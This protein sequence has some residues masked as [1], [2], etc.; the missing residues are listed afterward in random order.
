MM[1]TFVSQCEKNAL[2]KTRRVLDA[3]ANRIGDNTWQT[4]ITEDGLQTVKKM[5]RKTA[6]RSTAVSCHWI[7]SRSRTQL[8]WVVGNRLKFNAEG[9]VPVNRTQLNLEHKEWEQGWYLNEAVV[10]AT[11]IAALWHDFG[12]AN[13]LFQSK[14]QGLTE[15]KG[16]P[17]RHEWVS[18]R[19]FLAFVKRKPD[20]EWLS[21]LA[22]LAEQTLAEQVQRDILANLIRDDLE[23]QRPF[24]SL[25]PFAKLVAWLVVTHHRTLYVQSDDVVKTE[26]IDNW[27]NSVNC[28]WNSTNEKLGKED[29][30]L[31][32]KNWSFGNG[33][34]LLSQTWRDKAN[35]LAKRALNYPELLNRIDWFEQRFVAHMARLSLM[36]ADHYYSSLPLEQ[37][38]ATW[39]D[40][41]YLAYANTDRATNQLKQKLDQHNIGVAVNAQRFAQNLPALRHTL[42]ALAQHKLFTRRSEN[43]KYQWQDRAF[44]AAKEV[45]TLSERQG[46]FGVNMASTGCGKTMANA[47]IMY[48]LSDERQG[49]RFSVALGLR[50]LT[51]QTGDAY[52]DLLK[53]GDDELAVLIGSQAVKALH[54]LNQQQEFESKSG[55][56]SAEDLL[57]QLYVSYEGQIYDGRLKH[58]LA[59]SPKLEQLVSAPILVSTIDHLMPASESLRGGKQIAPMLR[60]LSSDL[61]LDEP[62]D[63]G[64]ED[65]P[66]LCRLVNWAGMLGS[67][68]LLSSATLPPSLISTLFDAYLEGRKQFNQANFAG[69]ADK[70]VVCAWFD[71]FK[72][73]TAELVDKTSFLAEHKAF[74]DKRIVKLGQIEQVI[75]KGALVPITSDSPKTEAVYQTVA[76]TIYQQIHALHQQ[77]HVSHP[78][79][80]KVSLGVVRMANIKPMMA[81]AK[82]LTAMAPDADTSIHFCVYHSQYPLALRSHKE[83]RLDAILTRHDANA[84]WQHA[85][86]AQALEATQTKNNIFVVLGT[87]VVEVGRD[88]DYDWA[89]AEPSSLRSLIQLAGRIQRHRQLPPAT[90]NLMVLS[91]NVRALKGEVPAYAKPGFESRELPLASHDLQ[92]LLDGELEAIS[93]IPRIVEP[94]KFLSKS[95]FQCGEGD[96]ACVVNSFVIQEHRALRIAL[97]DI[98][99]GMYRNHKEASLWWKEE[100]AWSGEFVHQTEFRQ[101]SPQEALVLRYGDDDELGWYQLDTTRKPYCYTAKN[102]SFKADACLLARG[103]Y[104]WFDASAEVIYQQLAERL[105]IDA[106]KASE[107]FGEIRLRM[108]HKDQVAIEWQWHPQ[109]GVY[110]Q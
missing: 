11:S 108:P 29:P 84:L 105:A 70:P 66:A 60:L 18:L 61:V 23:P 67:R 73:V 22:G 56:E 74:V 97:N 27:L 35:K 104:W 30:A 7:R 63:F 9:V 90:P 34:P 8:L 75:R 78:S 13:D 45:A 26:N 96:K 85:E 54:Q 51:L 40:V 20:H 41:N 28:G 91:Q 31:C 16:E 64:L 42:P 80:R 71:E 59:A 32:E 65:L 83:N 57:D 110:E 107:Q 50:T 102:N 62:D 43:A 48:A 81:V 109:L 77:H 98:G 21:Q 72:S 94:P 10:L 2:K 24:I 12:K 33:L 6:S 93:A 100:I 79:G 44:K 14:L 106:G 3:F 39:C 103:C 86:I 89:I 69:Q 92:Q 88:H 49:C 5:L 58:W 36:L 47:R 38:K 101:S 15:S 17:Y 37:S 99:Q 68:V 52:R 1:V 53:L 82:L 46:F 87:S 55:S 95:N 4:L 19:L 25:A 76:S